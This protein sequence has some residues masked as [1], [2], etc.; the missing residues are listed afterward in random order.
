MSSIAKQKDLILQNHGENLFRKRK[1]KASHEDIDEALF[2]WFKQAKSRNVSI[3]GP[4][5]KEKACSLAKG[6]DINYFEPSDSWV[7][8]WRDRRGIVF[9]KQQGE[10]QDHD[11]VGAH[12]GVTGV[13]PEISV[14]YVAMKLGFIL[15]HCPMAQ[16]ASRTISHSVGKE[17]KNV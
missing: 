8:R 12:D 3:N 1:R 16:C 4:L 17:L 5:L 13:W 11:S 14:K 15:K 6:L 10:K 9:K 2:R 7:Q